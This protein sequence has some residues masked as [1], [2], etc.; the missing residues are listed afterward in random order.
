MGQS[1]EESSSH[2]EQKSLWEQVERQVNCPQG[3][4]QA[5]LAGLL[6][7]DLMRQEGPAVT[8]V[9]NALME[10][11]TICNQPLLSRLHVQVGLHPASIIGALEG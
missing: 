7:R 10:L 2:V 4:Y 5:A 8:G 9:Q 6:S 11:R 3:A 1:F